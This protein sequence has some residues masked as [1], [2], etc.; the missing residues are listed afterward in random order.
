[1]NDIMNPK[2]NALAKKIISA[3]LIVVIIVAMVVGWFY[4]D[5]AFGTTSLGFYNSQADPHRLLLFEVFDLVIGI[6]TI[7]L[8]ANWGWVKSRNR[9]TKH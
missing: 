3:A 2:M 1:M 7:F 6:A 9:G 4:I 8:L 5:I